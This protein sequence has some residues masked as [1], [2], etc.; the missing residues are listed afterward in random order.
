MNPD[1]TEETSD[2]NTHLLTVT[3]SVATDPML[4]NSTEGELALAALELTELMASVGPHI[5]VTHWENGTSS[6][7]FFLSLN[8]MVYREGITKLFHPDGEAS[9]STSRYSVETDSV[10]VNLAARTSDDQPDADHVSNYIGTLMSRRDTV[11]VR[12]RAFKIMPRSPRTTLFYRIVLTAV[13]TYVF[14]L[15]YAVLITK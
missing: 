13:L 11:V 1:V 12:R 2:S 8:S 9:S 7:R 15:I 6:T 4:D 3:T 5:R 10:S 14:C